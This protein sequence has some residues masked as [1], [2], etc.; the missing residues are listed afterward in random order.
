MITKTVQRTRTYPIQID[1]TFDFGSGKKLLLS[2]FKYSE[3]LKGAR[4]EAKW[5]DYKGYYTSGWVVSK[6]SKLSYHVGH[7][8]IMGVFEAPIE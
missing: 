3:T 4:H 7:H 5:I 8:A 1:Y 6:Q 2:Y